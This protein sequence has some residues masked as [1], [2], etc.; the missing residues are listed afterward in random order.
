[1]EASRRHGSFL[2]RLRPGAGPT[3][4]GS[5]GRSILRARRFS[6]LVAF[7][8]KIP[9]VVEQNLLKR[10]NRLNCI[11]P[12]V[13]VAADSQNPRFAV[14]VLA[15]VAVPQLVAIRI[16]SVETSFAEWERYVGPSSSQTSARRS[17]KSCESTSPT[18]SPISS[19]FGIFPVEK[20]PQPCTRD[21]PIT[22][23]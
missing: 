3:F 8:N 23:L 19:S 11:Q 17:A 1:M 4:G 7:Q 21:V 12:D 18:Y 9:P 14:R 6:F 2:T 5:C 13:H 10:I 15:V 22:T 16:P 20:T